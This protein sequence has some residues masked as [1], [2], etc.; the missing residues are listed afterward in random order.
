MGNAQHAVTDVEVLHV[1]RIQFID[2]VDE[3]VINHLREETAFR[4]SYYDDFYALAQKR[5][6]KRAEQLPELKDYLKDRATLYNTVISKSR[7]VMDEYSN[8]KNYPIVVDKNG[9]R[10]PGHY[11]VRSNVIKT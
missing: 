10:V 1:S 2:H 6:E 7:A 4:T 8:R 5:I 11:H 9:R 3:D